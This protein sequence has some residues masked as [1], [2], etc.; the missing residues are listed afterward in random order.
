MA[1]TATSQNPSEP[2]ERLAHYKQKPIPDSTATMA[3]H[4][5]DHSY[6]P[7]DAIQAAMKTTMLTG[8]V[9]L[10][11]SAVQN[12]LTRKNVGPFGVFVR[13]GGTIGVFAA[14]GGTYEF[15]KTASANLREKEDHWNVALGGFF[16]GTILGLRARTFPALLG[17]GAALATFMGAFEYTGGSLWGYKK[18]ADI[19]EF[20][21]REQLRK[22][23][24]TSGEQTLAEL[25]EGRGLYGPGYAE[26][27]AQRI[28]EAYGIE[29]PTSQAPA[30]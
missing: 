30:S 14:M 13:S 21:R 29:V 7:K 26:R 23:Y 28:K 20:E 11:A 9:G 24:R 6:H 3:G 8:G 1:E 10:F 22:S 17:Y 4:T 5:E 25:G 12:T 18:N 2:S 27:R 16:S 19:D 15:V